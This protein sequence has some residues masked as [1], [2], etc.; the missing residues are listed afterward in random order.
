MLMWGPRDMGTFG[1]GASPA[2]M[3]EA[4]G[5]LWSEVSL[6]SAMRGPHSMSKAPASCVRCPVPGTLSLQYLSA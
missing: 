5:S 1:E 3:S 4:Q 6:H 2:L